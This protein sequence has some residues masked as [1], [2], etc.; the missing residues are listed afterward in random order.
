MALVIALLVPQAASAELED[1]VRAMMT[2][3]NNQLA[4]LGEDFRLEVVD[5][6]TIDESGR[7]VLFDDRTLRLTSH[8]VPGDPRRGVAHNDILWVTDFFDGTATGLSF[9]DTQTAVFNAMDTWNTVP[10]ATIP[11]TYLGYTTIDVGYV[12]WLLGFGGIQGFFFDITQ[13]GWITGDFFDAL[14]PGGSNFILGVT[15][16]FIWLEGPGGPPTDIDGNGKNDVAFREINYN[17]NFLWSNDGSAIDA[18]TIVLHEMGHG[19]SLGHFGTLF[20][21]LPNGKY[22]WAPKAVMNAGYVGDIQRE[23][24]GTDNAAFC[25]LW[26]SWPNN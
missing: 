17:N 5:L 2:T 24:L 22:H 7:R 1:D 15:F 16:T 9:E 10:C 3:V 12:Q 13:A 21:T 20:Q 11:L 23:L 26:A 18:E 6:I 8:W 25:S 4:A 19:L 14:A